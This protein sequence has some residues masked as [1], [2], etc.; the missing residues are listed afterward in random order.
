MM[1]RPGEIDGSNTAVI[2]GLAPWIHL[3]VDTRITAYRPVR[4]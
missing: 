3:N 1:E 2:H 4:A